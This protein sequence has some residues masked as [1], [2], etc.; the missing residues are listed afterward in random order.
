MSSYSRMRRVNSIILQVLASEVEVL[1]D[2]RL[3]MVSLTGV[4]TAPNLRRATVYFSTLDLDQS[5]ETKAAL[6]SAAPRLRKILGDEVR[7]K[8][9]P[10]LEFELDRGVAGGARIDQLLAQISRDHKVHDQK[11]EEE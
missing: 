10:A 2:P 7:M 5:G 11:D 6:E 1:K 3:G 4:D 9:T 8:Y